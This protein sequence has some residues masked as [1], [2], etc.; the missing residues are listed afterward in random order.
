MIRVNLLEIARENE[1]IAGV[2]EGFAPL[3]RGAVRP[4]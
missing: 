2:R 4:S 1:L 3:D